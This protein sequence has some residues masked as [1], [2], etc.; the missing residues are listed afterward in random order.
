MLN[1]NLL[2]NTIIL[3]IVLSSIYF[4][5]FN[6]DMV[7]FCYGINNNYH[8]K[9]YKLG[10]EFKNNLKNECLNTFKF[11]KYSIKDFYIYQEFQSIITKY[12]FDQNINFDL[13][14]ENI[15]KNEEIY[16]V[17][18]KLRVLAIAMIIIYISSLYIFFIVLPIFL[19]KFIFAI[20]SYILYL[21][22]IVLV[23]ALFLKNI[24]YSSND[25][26]K[27]FLNILLYFDPDELKKNFNNYTK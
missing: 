10:L 24:N 11:E 26:Y 6:R 13:L 25:I 1:A 12:M 5:L 15:Y 8:E 20:I 27:T 17:I 22:I 18:F 4:L 9:N 21:I 23:T 19:L 2:P 14:Y 3:V 7:S 16:V